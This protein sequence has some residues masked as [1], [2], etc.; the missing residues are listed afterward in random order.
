MTHLELQT[1]REAAAMQQFA[2]LSAEELQ[3]LPPIKWRVKHVLPESGLAAIYGPSGSGKT[4]L[5]LDLVQAIVSGRDWFGTKVRPSPVVYIALEGEGGVS[6]R[7]KAAV[8]C[9][10]SFGDGA[11]FMVHP[12]DLLNPVMV[13]GLADSIRHSSSTSGVVIIDTLN[14]AANI[15]ENSSHDM[16]QV[17][18]ACKH[19][20]ELVGGLVVLVHHTGKNADKGL[21][22]HSSLNAALDAAIEVSRAGDCREWKLA[23]SKDGVDGAAHAFT[24]ESVE[25]GIDDDGE[26][27][28]SCVIRPLVGVPQIRQPKLP[29]GGNQK[30]VLDAIEELLIKAGD[31]RPI[32]APANLPEGRP[33]VRLDK[34]IEYCRERLAVDSKRKNERAQQ[35]I[36][37]LVN[38]GVIAVQS[39]WIWR[40]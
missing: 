14:R 28:T 12:F 31:V 3:Q 6:T 35:A 7:V 32:D 34:A 26:D 36:T 19:L 16:G 1:I 25:V 4:F 38:R 27:I 23:K 2:L 11:R 39:D 20:E 29:T 9:H 5:V 21:R 18:S 13:E 17:I 40:T 8:T 24:L 15:D 33:C 30:V 37:G 10:G 22:G